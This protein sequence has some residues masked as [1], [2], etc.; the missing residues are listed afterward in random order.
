MSILVINAG[1]S[2]VKFAL[3]ALDSLDLLARGLLDWAGN[4]HQAEF[5]L[6][7]RDTEPQRRQL[8]AP[9]YRRAVAGA[10][11]A[12][13]Q[14]LSAHEI[15]PIRV[16]GHRLIHAG[17]DLDRPIWIDSEAKRRIS[18]FSYLAPLHIPAGLQ[19]IEAAEEAIPSAPQMGVFDT[20][21]FSNMPP[22]AYLYP[23][24]YEW[25]ENWGIRRLGY[26]GTSHRY[27]AERAA[28]MLSRPLEELRLV[29]C[30]L[31]QGCSATVVRQGKPL[32]NTLGFSPLDGLMMGTRCGAVD[33]GIITYVQKQKGLTVEQ[34][35]RVLYRESGLLGISGISSDFRQVAAAAE[36]GH[37]RARLALEIYAFRV[38]AAIGAL[39]AT[40]G[41]VDALVFTGGVGENASQ[42]RAE[43]VE[44]LA[45]LGLVVDCEANARCRPDADVAH[46]QSPA[47]VLIITTRED[48]MIARDAQRMLRERS[49]QA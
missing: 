19:A 48:Y 17:T 20:A 44:G 11:V 33:P 47:R 3:F 30:H 39:A 15:A 35:E 13:R 5:T 28:Q 42:L 38:R 34:V 9:D 32:L 37:E 8:A 7:C 25:Y 36:L 10:L 12:L 14:Q 22:W 6:H 46:Q 18:Q 24:P 1:S 4:E 29:I 16:V 31:G 49:S 26:H 27:C 40:A 41:G 21:Y 23:V 45:C 2:S 43:I